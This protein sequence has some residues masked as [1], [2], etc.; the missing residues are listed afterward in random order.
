MNKQVW[1]Y[2]WKNQNIELEMLDGI[3]TGDKILESYI[4]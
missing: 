3:M 4:Y 1:I 2:W